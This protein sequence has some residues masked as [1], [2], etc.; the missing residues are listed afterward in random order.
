MVMHE[1]H[2]YV[3]INLMQGFLNFPPTAVEGIDFQDM[4]EV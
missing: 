3:Y 4:A 1:Q 2:N